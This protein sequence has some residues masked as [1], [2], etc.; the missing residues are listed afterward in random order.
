MYR[1]QVEAERLLRRPLPQ[2]KREMLIMTSFIEIQVK[3]A[4]TALYFASRA[5]GISPKIER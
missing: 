5:N 2:S 4:V 1:F 3:Y